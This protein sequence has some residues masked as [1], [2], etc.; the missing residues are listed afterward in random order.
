MGFLG[1]LVPD[2]E[3][4]LGGVEPAAEGEVCFVVAGDQ[5]GAVACIADL[6]GAQ[7]GE[8]HFFALDITDA[9]RLQGG[10]IIAGVAV[11][12]VGVLCQG[13]PLDPEADKRFG[14]VTAG[15]RGEDRRG[16]LLGASPLG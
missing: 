11:P 13:I 8:G 9:H 3:G 10:L 2:G 12:D 6:V 14:L 7:Q 1:G 15:D 5:L 16:L 4:F